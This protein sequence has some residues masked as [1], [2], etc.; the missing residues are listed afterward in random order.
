MR[1]RRPQSRKSHPQSIANVA[2]H[3][4]RAA[5]ILPTVLRI[6]SVRRALLFFVPSPPH[7]NSPTRVMYPARRGRVKARFFVL[8]VLAL[9]SFIDALV[10]ECTGVI[11]LAALRIVVCFHDR[12][13]KHRASAAPQ[14]RGARNLA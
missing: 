1:Q 11:V 8:I 13:N 9:P 7:S 5:K 10:R 2:S 14:A 3:E 12:R 4:R 6:F